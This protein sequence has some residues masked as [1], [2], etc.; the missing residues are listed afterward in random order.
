MFLS[1]SRAFTRVLNKRFVASHGRRFISTET[2]ASSR[3]GNKTFGFLLSGAFGLGLLMQHEPNYAFMA[4]RI[5]T[6]GDVLSVG[7]PV[8]EEA[9][10]IPFPQLCN[11]FRLVGQGVRVKY[12]FVKVSTHSH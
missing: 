4:A 2:L 3:A 10:G 9:T 6:S 11:G 12:V 5:P 7:M 1:S 8:T